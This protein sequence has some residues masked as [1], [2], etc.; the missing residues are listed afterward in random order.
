M[1]N[2]VLE[3]LMDQED[4]EVVEVPQALELLDNLEV[5]VVEMVVQEHLII[6]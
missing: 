3:I 2:L 1:D 5:Q 6:F 4:L